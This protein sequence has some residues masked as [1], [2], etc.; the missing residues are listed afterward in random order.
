MNVQQAKRIPLGKLLSALGHEPKHVDNGEAWYLS[1]FRLETEPSFKLTASQLGWFDHGMGKGGNIIDFAMVYWRVS[2]VSDALS[3]LEKAVGGVSVERPSPAP[4]QV[5]EKDLGTAVSVTKIE[6]LANRALI[7]YL[8]RRGIDAVTARPY[9]QEIYYT[10]S[11]R[12][13]FG[14]AF[15]NRSG[16]YEIRN[17]YFKGSTGHKDITLI[18]GQSS[19]GVMVFEGFF[20]F[21]SALKHH[22]V[23]VPPLSVLVLNSVAMR[24]RA[25]ETLRQMNISQAHLYLDHDSAGRELTAYFQQQLTG[26][27][28]LDQSGVYAG[29]KDFN[30]MLEKQRQMELS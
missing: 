21:L 14:L 10:Y 3:A 5:T 26:I 17:P 8:G 12:R 4:Q 16:G 28:V 2:T 19:D 22:R 29:H 7:D 9:V 20:D 18:Q 13:Y 1:P 15:P 24:D 11:Y 23:I 27:A 25:M 6:P 30:A